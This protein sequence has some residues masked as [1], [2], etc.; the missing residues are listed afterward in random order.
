MARKSEVFHPPIHHTFIVWPH[1]LAKQT[2]LLISVLIRE[3]DYFSRNVMMSVGVSSMGKTRVVF[4]DSG[5]KV[6][7]SYYCNIVLEKGLLQPDIRAICGHL[8]VDTAAG[9][10]ASTHRP[11]HDGLAYL[12][13]STSTSLN[14]TCGLQIA[15]ILI[16]WVML[17]GVLFSNE[18]TTNDN[19]RRWKNWSER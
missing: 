16:P 1:Y 12:K 9:W 2:L 4:I 5:A 8:Q 15:L 3:R 13:K 7:S 6:N 18:S 14:L 10:S 19:S 17:F 11:D